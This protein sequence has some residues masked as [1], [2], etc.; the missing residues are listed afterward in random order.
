MPNHITNSLEITHAD[1]KKIT[2]LKKCFITDGEDAAN[3]DFAKI[4]PPPNSKAY[5][6]LPDQET[7]K[8]SPDWWYNWNCE[9][10]GTKWNSY[11]GKI[12]QQSKYKIVC[13]FDTAWGPPEPIFAKLEEMGFTVGGLWKDEGDDQVHT[14]GDGGNWYT[15]IDFDYGG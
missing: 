14:I 12:I 2:W 11:H 7:A 9:H 6:D 3:L 4:I 5:K 13:Q 8:K 10:W 15:N 1:A